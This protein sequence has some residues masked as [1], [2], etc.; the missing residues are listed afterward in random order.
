MNSERKVVYIK[1]IKGRKHYVVRNSTQTNDSGD[2]LF[3]DE[4]RFRK[5]MKEEA[6]KPLLLTRSE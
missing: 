3:L 6:A 1:V 2:F 5:I 4:E